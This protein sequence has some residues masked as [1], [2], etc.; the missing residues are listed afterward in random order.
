MSTE[1]ET[2]SN[3]ND[4]APR[5]ALFCCRSPVCLNNSPKLVPPVEMEH[6]KLL[7][8]DERN[9]Y[10]V[11]VPDLTDPEFYT[12]LMSQPS[13]PNHTSETILLDDQTK[14]VPINKSESAQDIR[15]GVALRRV[16]PPKST[17]TVKRSDA[18]L[19]N[20]VLRKVEKK[21][22]EPPKPIKHERSPPP[23]KIPLKSAA[24]LAVSASTSAIVE[25][26]SKNKKNKTRIASSDKNATIAKSKS[27][28]DVIGNQKEKTIGT[29]V[30]PTNAKPPPPVNLLKVHR[31]LEVHRI[32][33]DKI[34]IIRR[35]PRAQRPHGDKKTTHSLPSSPL[36]STQV[37]KCQ[38]VY[39]IILFFCM[40]VIFSF[41]PFT[42]CHIVTFFLLFS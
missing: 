40:N 8:S 39:V 16:T 13:R 36:G 18:P 37:T 1:I 22:L 3:V 24:G 30:K 38:N 28:N 10:P 33:G 2:N 34:I 7:D 29:S 20:V 9:V 31:P 41:L 25:A 23:K 17:V 14:N 12:N 35:V 6:Q 15:H 4:C 19:M 27:T 11:T 5:N 42:F 26:N 32:E 21:L